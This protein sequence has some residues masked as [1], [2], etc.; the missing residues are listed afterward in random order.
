MT[1]TITLYPTTSR[2]RAL[3]APTIEVGNP[4]TGARYAAHEI[5]TTTTFGIGL[6]AFASASACGGAR[7][8]GTRPHDMT[9]AQHLDRASEHA[10]QAVAVGLAR[11]P[12][13]NPPGYPYYYTWYP[14]TEHR[15]LA[16]AH[17]DAAASLRAEYDVACAT[18]PRELQG[19]SPL[20]THAVSATGFSRGA[21]IQLDAA[22]G[23]PEALLDRLRCHRA[24][25]FLEPRDGFGDSPLLVG[26]TS[27][28]VH[29]TGDGLDVVI[30]A[31]DAAGAV[32]VARRA[33][34]TV[35]HARAGR[36]P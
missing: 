14:S 2:T 30:T 33:A 12:V 7:A 10:E 24:W 17:R 6:L 32:E 25:L 15:E 8:N 31:T 20:D 19:V 13:W 1:R 22:A 27:W 21:L 35:E 28:V 34:L 3:G 29:A 23:P 36:V 16:E 26:G 9:A 18:V 5:M 11:A 4:P